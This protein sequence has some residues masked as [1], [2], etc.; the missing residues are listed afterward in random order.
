MRSYEQ[1]IVRRIHCD[2]CRASAVTLS[3][4]DVPPGWWESPEKQ[5]SL[6]KAL[7]PQCKEGGSQC[8]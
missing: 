3:G 2:C 4:N 7:C 5:Q 8:T 1:Y 6:R